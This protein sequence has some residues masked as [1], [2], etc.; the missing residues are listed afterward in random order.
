MAFDL[1]SDL[2][3]AAATL[4]AAAAVGPV[5]R[6]IQQAVDSRF[7]RSRYDA[8]QVAE[9]FAGRLRDQVDLDELAGDLRRVMAATVQPAHLSLWLRTERQ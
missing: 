3:V 7:N 5:R 2:L 8:A 4:L 6:R 9:D 1:E